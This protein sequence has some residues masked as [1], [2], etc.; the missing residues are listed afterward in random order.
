M[1]TLRHDLGIPKH[2][3]R[4][5]K[6]DNRFVVLANKSW[7]KC[8]LKHKR[9]NQFYTYDLDQWPDNS[10]QCDK[11]KSWMIVNFCVI[12]KGSGKHAFA[13]IQR[14]FESKDTPLCFSQLMY[15][16]SQTNY[17]NLWKFA[18]QK[19]S[20]VT[21]NTFYQPNNGKNIDKKSVKRIS[22]D[23]A[24]K[25][26]ITRMYNVPIVQCR[27]E[28]EEE[29]D[30]K[31]C[32]SSNENSSFDAQVNLCAVVAAIETNSSFVIVY[33]SFISNNLLDCVTYSPALLSKSYNKPLFLIYQILQLMNHLHLRGQ[34]LGNIHLSDIYLKQNLWLYICPQVEASILDCDEEIVQEKQQNEAN[35]KSKSVFTLQEYC[36]M[37]SQGKLSNYDYLTILNNLSGRRLGCPQFHHIMPWVTDF[38]SRNGA[39]WR[40]LKKSKYRLN[41]GDAQL[42]LMFAQSLEN[43]VPHHVSDILSEITYFVYMARRTPKNILCENVRSKWIP[44]EYPVSVQRLQEWTPDECIPEFFSDPLVFKSIHEDLMDLEVPT[45][46][47][48]PEDFI[49]KHREALESQHVSERLH[50]WIDLNFGYKLTGAAAVKSKNVCLSMVDDHVQLSDHGTVQLFNH[51]HPQKKYHTPWTSNVP[52]RI[53]SHHDSRRLT[54]SSEDISNYRYC[55]SD[56]SQSDWNRDWNAPE[57]SMSSIERSASYHMNVQKSQNQIILPKDYNPV[58][59]LNMIENMEAFI[60]NTFQ[61]NLQLDEKLLAVPT[62]LRDNEQKLTNRNILQNYKQVMA[63]RCYR[64][65]QVLGC[66][67]VEIFLAKQIRPLSGLCLQ[68]FEKRVEVCSNILKK[69]LEL[70]PKCVQYPAIMLLNSRENEIIT[71]KGLPPPSAHQLLQPLLNNILFPFPINFEKAYHLIKSLVQFD[72]ATN[73]LELLTFS[74]TNDDKQEAMDKVRVAFYRKIAACKVKTCVTQ[75][76]DLL[77]PTAYEQ[78]DVVDIILPHITDMLTN[79]ET[80][81]LVA[82]YLFDDLAAALGPKLSCE[83]LLGPILHLY[84]TDN[85]ERLKFLHSNYDFSMKFS[86][87]S[88]LKSIKAVKLYHHSF[89]QRLII[90]FG[91][92]TFL[93]NF[94]SPLIE[95]VGGYKELAEMEQESQQFGFNESKKFSEDN[96]TEKMDEESKTCTESDEMFTFDGE[97]DGSKTTNA[98]ESNCSDNL[99]QIL[100][101]FDLS[102]EGSLLELRFNHSTAEEATE[103]IVVTNDSQENL[104]KISST[105]LGPKSPDIPIPTFRRSTELSTI[106]CEIGSNSTRIDSVEL[107]SQ[108]TNEQK[109]PMEQQKIIP[110]KTVSN[111]E[112]RISE[113]SAESLIWLSYRLGPILT[114]RYISRNLLKMLTLCY[115]GQENL[116]P[117]PSEDI[118][119]KENLLT[120]SISNGIVVGDVNAAKV[121]E[122]LTSMSALYGDQFVLLQY[123]PHVSELILLCKKRITSSLEG[124]L[125]SSLQLLKYLIPCLTDVVIMDQLHDIILKSIINPIIRLLGSSKCLMPSGFLA[126]GVLARKLI[127]LFYVIAIRIGPEM[128]REHLC[129]PALQRYFL[130]FDK[131]YGISEHFLKS[132]YKNKNDDGSSNSSDDSNFVEIRRAGAPREWSMYKGTSIQI[133]LAKAKGDSSIESI[134]P[135][136]L[137]NMEMG[138]ASSIRDREEIVEV[139]T[140]NLAHVSFIPFLKYLGEATMYQV[141]K[142]ISLI[143]NLCHEFEQPDCQ[144]DEYSVKFDF[145]RSGKIHDYEDSID[146]QYSNSFGT[147]VIGNRIQVQ[148]GNESEIGPTEMLD[149]VAYK[150]EQINASRHLTG[151]W[152]IYWEHE[153]GL[154]EKDYSFNLKQIKLQSFAGHSNSIRSICC[155]DNEN[156]FMSASKDKT[157]KLWS[158]RN[159]GD[160]KDT[161]SCQFTYTKHRKSVHSLAF[162]ESLRLAVSCDSGVHL[163]DPFDGSRISQLDSHK[164]TPISVVKTFPAPSPLILCGTAEST[165]KI[166]DARTFSYVNEFKCFNDRNNGGGS[167]RCLSISPNGKWVAMGLSSGQIC[168]FDG[169]SGIILSSWSYH[170]EL[171]QLVLTN[172]TLIS[173]SLDQSICVWKI[174]GKLLFQLKSPA[175]PVHCLI[176]NGKELIF[177]TPNNRIGVYHSVDSGSSCSVTKL[178]SEN[179]KGVVTSIS[180]LPLNRTLLIG[181][182]NGIITLFC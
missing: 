147:T 134:T 177:A 59:A 88:S 172:D 107:S 83:Y 119:K 144:L 62:E 98:D 166:I 46:A 171:L 114:G 34:F 109:K 72:S 125:I 64:D 97:M 138:S 57:D 95:A 137:M 76:K 5:T 58:A 103:G 130:I 15:Y 96:S 93:E 36:K 149:L 70:L 81:I 19:Y 156:S 80:G 161:S 118:P 41:K 1:E 139:F 158:L 140:P 49:A 2:Q 31:S 110:K 6:T 163:W 69:N 131:A 100:D 112:N 132:D 66:I 51:P 128:T 124:G 159:Q 71:E 123:F 27:I 47:T 30:D 29:C 56:S 39:N 111:H 168:V 173:T 94:I 54:K 167:V 10:K 23:D 120:F 143:L 108:Q 113:M 67:I 164:L 28:A 40:D 99:K 92:K 178:R 43:A 52:P 35:E 165:I 133:Q 9:V 91:L 14:D 102:S 68:S 160:G 26:V 21:S 116:I 32:S 3:I 73:L 48:C 37:W 8:L 174:D 7:L 127:D 150:F 105:T 13:P 176:S 11:L 180:L 24:L 115:V 20:N 90:R 122:C 25:D 179:F 18:H 75:I 126:R 77:E 85:E 87:N 50:H 17:Q 61:N 84:E 44:A 45:W 155:L 89:L 74:E 175:E 65:L 42:D 135:P 106:D 104:S 121:L 146:D 53:Y 22:Y 16:I 153:I 33:N 79:G 63:D 86:A 170:G 162:L 55:D 136:Q 4:T 157:V 78:F 60:S 141:V 129:V 169:L 152:A 38:A 12:P 101:Q 145:S 117:L 151:H 181:G 154:S 82:W 148:S 182:D 142:N